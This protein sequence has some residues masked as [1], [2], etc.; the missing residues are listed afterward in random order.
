MM[1]TTELNDQELGVLMVAL[2]YWRAHRQD[3]ATRQADPLLTGETLDLLVAKLDGA[4]LAPMPSDREIIFHHHL[5]H[6]FD[7][8]KHH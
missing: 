4:S 3:T 5:L 8:R 7:P 6:D 2:K 1:P